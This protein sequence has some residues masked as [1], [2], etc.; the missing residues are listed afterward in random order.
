MALEQCHYQSDKYVTNYIRVLD[1]LIDID[2]DVDLYVRK[3]ILVN[4]LGDSNAVT[5][6]VN[7]LNQQIFDS[8]MNSNYCCLCEKLNTFY[9]VPCHS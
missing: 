3:G 4:T 7:K 5:T 1:F 8:E 2:R 9:K 6:W